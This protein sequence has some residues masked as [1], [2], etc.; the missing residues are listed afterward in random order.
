MPQTIN[1]HSCGAANQ[2]PEGKN[3]MF[4]AFCG[5]TIQNISINSNFRKPNISKS[6]LSPSFIDNEVRGRK[7]A[8]IKRNIRRE[9][10][11]FPKF[12]SELFI[13]V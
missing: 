12:L 11:I 5:N 3:S 9:I 7:L 4:C 10:P 8:Y 1:C 2:L 6:E 13:S